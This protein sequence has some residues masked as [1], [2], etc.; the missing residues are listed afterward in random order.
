MTKLH[1]LSS[2]H[3]WGKVKDGMKAKAIAITVFEKCQ[4]VWAKI[5]KNEIGVAIFIKIWN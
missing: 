3:V 2:N 1:D 5:R 4:L